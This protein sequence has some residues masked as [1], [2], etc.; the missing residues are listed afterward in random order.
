MVLPLSDFA[1]QVVQLGFVHAHADSYPLA[2][3][4]RGSCPHT[5]KLFQA[6]AFFDFRV[7]EARFA[8]VADAGFGQV[9]IIVQ[10]LQFLAQRGDLLALAGD[11][12]DNGLLR[13]LSHKR[14]FDYRFCG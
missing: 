1:Q 8:F 7:G 3:W 9:E 14:L 4:V 6:V 10:I 12:A 2:G 13:G 5:A 11:G